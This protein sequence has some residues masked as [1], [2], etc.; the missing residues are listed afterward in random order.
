MEL[1]T[2][3]RPVAVN[4]SMERWIAEPATWQR[5]SARTRDE[6]GQRGLGHLADRLR[7]QGMIV[8][9]GYDE[10]FAQAL[11]DTVEELAA[12]PP[13][14]YR[15]RALSGLLATR[16]ETIQPTRRRIFFPDGKDWFITITGRE[17]LA[18]RAAAV[19]TERPVGGLISS[20]GIAFALM[21]E[22]TV[23]CAMHALHVAAT[24][25]LTDPETTE[26]DRKDLRRLLD[27]V[28]F[29]EVPGF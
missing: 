22:P 14:D 13:I 28:R 3:E 25:L 1:D 11:L 16:L 17:R 21:D 18:R 9:L 2:T 20:R 7:P 15:L 10:Q 12:R 8:D 26:P 23:R 4:I 5:I 6:L 24:A 19:P 27:E 29:G